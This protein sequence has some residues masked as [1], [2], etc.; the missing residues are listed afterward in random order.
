MQGFT[1]ATNRRRKAPRGRPGLYLAA[2]SALVLVGVVSFPNPDPS[3]ATEP[4]ARTHRSSSPVSKSAPAVLEG[5]WNAFGTDHDVAE[6]DID[7]FERW[8]ERGAGVHVATDLDPDG[9]WE[10]RRDGGGLVVVYSPSAGAAAPWTLEVRRSR[11]SGADWTLACRDL[12]CVICHTTVRSDPRSVSIDGGVRVAS[13]LEWDAGV[14]STLD[15]EGTLTEI[16]AGDGLPD[17]ERWCADDAAR[18]GTLEVPLGR[19]VDGDDGSPDHAAEGR[20]GPVEFEGTAD[21][22]LVA[23]GAVDDPMRIDGRV[24]VEGDLVIGG[25]IV[26]D[27]LV[28]VRGNVVV[29]GGLRHFGPGSV[30]IATPE[31]ILAGDVCRP[32]SGDERPVTGDSSG[33]LSFAIEALARFNRD[34]GTGA[35]FTWRDGVPAPRLNAS[36]SLGRWEDRNLVLLDAA[37]ARVVG[38]RG[39]PGWLSADLLAEWTRRGSIDPSGGADGSGGTT[40]EASLLAGG[41]FIAVARGGAVEVSPDASPEGAGPGQ[42]VLRGSLVAGH[43][44]IHAPAGLTVEDDARSRASWPFVS[45]RGIV[46]TIRPGPDPVV[47]PSDADRLPARR[48]APSPRGT[49]GDAR[50]PSIDD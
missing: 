20:L 48:I 41:A 36:R 40:I 7:A 43:A 11:W 19:S 24:L 21:G 8:L 25:S 37:G 10:H 4:G 2:I 50:T 14:G 45:A 47:V 46:R 5:L 32:R 39:D 38:P 34:V 44:A 3:P 35:P 16:P 22:H 18:T 13:S 27:G 31:S 15:L 29:V 33:S 9:S 26:G 12:S 23:W 17:I 1:R 6:C 30:R 42:V 49:R 28:T